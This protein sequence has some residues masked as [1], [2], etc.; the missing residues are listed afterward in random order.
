MPTVVFR[1]SCVVGPR[2][3]GNEDQGWVAHFLYSALHGRAVT[4]YGDGLQ[5]RDVLAISDLLNAIEAARA[6]PAAA[7]E[8]FN[9]GGGV[10]NTLSLLELHTLIPR[11][12]G[13]R[14]VFRFAPSRPGDQRVYVTDFS[15]FGGLTG[16]KPAT[17]VSEALQSIF[18][19]WR[20]NRALFGDERETEA[21]AIPVLAEEAA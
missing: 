18:H 2:Q 20:R 15:K 16:W 6:C 9:I 17:S 3:F 12:T 1:M 8:V 4:I 19:W 10:E 5:V 13:A 21:S 7:G 11:I 14:L